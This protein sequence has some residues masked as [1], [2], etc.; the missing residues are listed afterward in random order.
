MWAARVVLEGQEEE[1]KVP[2]EVVAKGVL[3]YEGVPAVQSVVAA[4]VVREVF[5]AGVVA[6]VV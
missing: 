5:W 4:M 1:Q 2:E 3:E 6:P